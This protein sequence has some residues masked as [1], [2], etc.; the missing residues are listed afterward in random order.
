M[1]ASARPRGDGGGPEPPGRAT[2]AWQGLYILVCLRNSHQ[3]SQEHGGQQA[4]LAGQGPAPAR[5]M[6]RTRAQLGNRLETCRV[7]NCLCVCRAAKTLAAEA[8][9]GGLALHWARRRA[10][11]SVPE[12]VIDVSLS[13][14]L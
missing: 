9:R 2:L 14:R 1:A 10:R 12:L 11:P 7:F 6:E 13:P 5:D 8:Q 4:P 3:S